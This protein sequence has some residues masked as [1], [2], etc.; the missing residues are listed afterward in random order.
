V[1]T[2]FDDLKF[3]KI[4]RQQNVYGKIRKNQKHN[5]PQ[6]EGLKKT[7]CSMVDEKIIGITLFWAAGNSRVSADLY[8]RSL[9]SLIS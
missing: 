7:P 8:F 5:Y 9:L 1:Q 4:E 3:S 6:D 2:G